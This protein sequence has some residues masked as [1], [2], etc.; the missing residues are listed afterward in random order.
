MALQTS[1]LRATLSTRRLALVI[2]GLMLAMLMNAVETMIVSTAMPRVIADLNGLDRYAWV[3]T[4]YMLASTVAIPIYGKLS[5]IYGRRPFFLGGMLVFLIG[6]ALSG[7]SQDMNQL[8]VS[9]SI[10]G[11]G[12]GGMMPLS[13]AVVGDIFPPRERGKWQGVI[14]SLWALGTIFGPTLGGWISDNWGWRWVF[15]MNMPVGA[16]TLVTT[17]I[18]MPGLTARREHT[19]DY[20]G[21]G[22][23]A[24]GTVA[25]L[26]ALSWAGSTYAWFSFQILGTLLLAL[27]SYVLF[28]RVESRAAEPIM[29]ASYFRNGIFAV[30]V[31]ATFLLSAGMFSNLQYTPLFVQ[32]VIGA[33][34][35]SSGAVMTA[36]MIAFMVSNVVTG[37]LLSRM[38]RYKL[39]ATGAFV[40]A[41]A[42]TLLF[43]VMNIHTTTAQ[44]T[45]NMVLTGL[46]IGMGSL[47][48]IVVQNAFPHSELGQ[49]TA[50][51]Q[52]FRSIGGTMGT[53]LLGTVLTNSFQ[54]AF[55]SN[56]TLPLR[57]ALPPERL[58][59][60]QNPQVLLTPAASLQLQ[61]NLGALG[62]QGERLFEQMVPVLRASLSDAITSVF[63]VCAILMLL[64]LVATLFL[65][66]IP[67]R[68]TFDSS[69][70]P[71]GREEAAGVD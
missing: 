67:L 21:A 4:A 6:S 10:Q 3:F 69:Q 25:L 1:S 58:G 63:T 61:Q 22:L 42:G 33:S 70:V 23:L 55:Q 53:A 68:S 26:L 36:H 57:N 39:L 2:F 54:S 51:L 60:F 15:Y 44:V 38:G 40:L 37:Q 28:L 41:L 8:I 30:S 7:A 17:G 34:A 12:A 50:T 35:T 20:L 18:A 43:A 71:P 49:V 27:V 5:D 62:P 59:E 45:R 47:F 19:I 9:R 11:L 66:E 14:M 29:R 31:I 16:L 64:G 32:G 46:G 52:F 65:R 56:L 48:V 13:Q 24:A